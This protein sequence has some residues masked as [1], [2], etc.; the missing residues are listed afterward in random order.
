MLRKEILEELGEDEDNYKLPEPE[1]A[2][3]GDQ[4]YV[5]RPWVQEYLFKR[6]KVQPRSGDS[7]KEL[8]EEER[9]ERSMR[10]KRMELERK[11]ALK[12]A[13]R[14]AKMNRLNAVDEENEDGRGVSTIYALFQ[15]KKSTIPLNSIL[16]FYIF[17]KKH[18]IFF[19]LQNTNKHRDSFWYLDFLI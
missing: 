19:S 14:R 6:H 5:K 13:L 15:L 3:N 11:K 2:I 1:L 12:K 10:R 18:V 17:K 7:K 9:L 4:V 8:T 16:L